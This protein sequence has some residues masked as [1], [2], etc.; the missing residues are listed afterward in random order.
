MQNVIWK[1]LTHYD[2]G[3]LTRRELMQGL[4]VLA[5]ASTTASAAGFQCSSINHVSIQVSDLQ[6]ST[7]WYKRMFGL[8]EQKSNNQNVVT[9]V[10]GGSHLSIKVGQPAGSVDHFALGMEHFDQA[11]V[12]QE[13]KQ[14]GPIEGN[15]AVGGLTVKDPDGLTVQLSS[16]SE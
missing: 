9:L 12:A 13:L 3:T 14:R 11:A 5:A 16:S 10:V 4:A 1:L 8:S 15:P 2:R 7:E 6:R